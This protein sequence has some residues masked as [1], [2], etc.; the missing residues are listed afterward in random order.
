MGSQGSLQHFL[1]YL[2]MYSCHYDNQS[3]DEVIWFRVEIDEVHIIVYARP[4]TFSWSEKR[5]LPT[6][7]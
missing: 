5:A 1:L 2:V 3:R 7:Y 4:Q 6:F